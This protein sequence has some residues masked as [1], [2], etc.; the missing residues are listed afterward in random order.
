[1][2][3]SLKELLSLLRSLAHHSLGPQLSLRCID[4]EIY[5]SKDLLPLFNSHPNIKL[6]P[7]IKALGD[8][9]SSFLHIHGTGTSSLVAYVHVLLR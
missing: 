4:G 5:P 8:H 2:K 1:M 7:Y 9:V 6:N 3:E